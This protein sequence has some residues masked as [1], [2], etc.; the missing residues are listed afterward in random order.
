MAANVKTEG[1]HHIGLTVPDVE[2]TAAFFIDVLNFEKV[3][4]RPAY[5]AIFVSDGSLMVTLWQ[6]DAGAAA[7]DRRANCG[8]HHMAFKVADADALAAVHA[9]I[10]A[11]PGAEV[12]FA[13]E[14]LNAGPTRHM[15]CRVPGGLRI[16]FIAP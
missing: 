6:A 13:P 7:F 12:E 10:D 3:G 9:A 1:A 5:P 4:G 8:L 2:E 15:M 16:E 14:P 11:A